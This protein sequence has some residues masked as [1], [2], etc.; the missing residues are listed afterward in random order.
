MLLEREGVLE[1]L[2]ELAAASRHGRGR[3]VLV[4]GEAGIGK[5]SAIAAFTAGVGRETA[6]FWGSSDAVAPPRAFAAISDIAERTGGPLGEAL[7]AA[8]RDRVFE[9]FL[10][11]IRRGPGRARIIVMEDLHWADQAT[12]DLLRVAGPRLREAPALLIATF[13]DDEVGAQHPLRLALGDVPADDVVTISVPPLSTG[14]VTE[15]ARE[16]LIDP[17]ALHRLTAGNPFYV[18]EVIGAYGAGIPASVQAAV[19]ART[20]RLT[21]AAREVLRA[22]AVLGPRS[23]SDLVLA[24]AGVPAEA[25]DECIARAA[26]AEDAGSVSFR[27]EIA[28]RSIIESIPAAARVALHA[29]ALALLRSEPMDGDPSPLARH[30]V[31]ANDADA[32]VEFAP[33]A[34]DRAAALG[35]HHEAVEH[36]AS[37]LRFGSRLGPRDRARLLQSHARVN[38]LLNDIDGARKSQS[39]AMALWREM[40]DVLGQAEC[41]RGSSWVNWLAG[42]ADAAMRSAAQAVALL[43]HVSPVGREHG[44]AYAT[45]AQR[46]MTTGTEDEK[47]ADLAGVALKIAEAAG[48]EAT[49]VHALTTAGAAEIYHGSESGWRRLDEAVTR[50]KAAD[51]AEEVSRALINIVEGGLDM[52]QLDIADRY[53]PQATAWLADRDLDLYQGLNASRMAEL[54]LRRGRWNEAAEVAETLLRRPST[55][56]PIRVRALAIRARIAAR[57][58]E[59][60][61]WPF[62]NEA[63]RL[64]ELSDQDL[65]LTRTARIEVALTLGEAEQAREEGSAA[66]SMVTDGRDDPAAS[67]G[68]FWAWRARAIDELPDFVVEPFR[69]HSEGRLRES[70]SAWSALGCSFHEALALADSQDEDDLRGALQIFH[71]L[72]AVPH[73]EGVAQR[74]RELGV[75]RLPR[76]PRAATRGNPYGLTA[77]EIEVLGLLGRS[78]PNSEIARRLVLSE[79]TVD[80]H[81]AA[82]LRKLDVHDRRAAGAVARDLGRKIGVAA[83]QT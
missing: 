71:Q 27:H 81:V 32:I 57:R 50:A 16:T 37:A 28:R 52:W 17:G 62:L 7:K 5:T 79:K 13:R 48:D 56:T 83:P 42:D 45:L 64:A 54:A 61:P 21:P 18:T 55:A 76:G 75:T 53:G 19:L 25:L 3:L 8:D 60:D 26:L 24:L 43:E 4:T 69:L 59:W 80:K 68:L 82:V 1:R 9:A 63:L 67:E 74:L 14:A 11:L 51:L 40:G 10:A 38:A 35:A 58:G 49:A 46:L 34:G 47:A 2:R 73:A 6:V 72:G 31:A 78:L 39:E 20:E 70:A 41:L 29:R 33:L 12:L 65:F 15:L 36:Y 77:R 66:L 30:A 23:R 44:R 22:A